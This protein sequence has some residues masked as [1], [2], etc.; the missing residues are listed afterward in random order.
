LVDVDVETGV[1]KVEE[2]SAVHDCGVVI[3]PKFVDGQLYGA[4]VQ[5]IGGALWEDQPYDPANGRPLSKTLKHY[6]LPRAPDVPMVRLG[7]QQTPSPFTL[8]GTKGAGES[9]LAGAMAAITN[10]VNDA[11]RPLGVLAHRLPLNPHNIL[12]AIAEGAER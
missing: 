1:V 9:G 11:L 12:T 5:G 7:H 6:L 4:I 8:L 3:S 2:Y 10:A